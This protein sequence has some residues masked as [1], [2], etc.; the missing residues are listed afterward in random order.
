MRLPS[1]IFAAS[2][3][4]AACGQAEPHIYPPSARKEFAKAC[5]TGKPEC[6]CTWKEITIA[7]PSEEF[8]RAM[9]R[10]LKEGVMDRRVTLASS[11][12]SGR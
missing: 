12:C 5:P 11:K 8:D 7:M 2:L 4:L 6:D 1:I 9:K 10:Y 3:A